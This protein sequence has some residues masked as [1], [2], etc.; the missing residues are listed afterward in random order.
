MTETVRL[1][2]PSAGIT[3]RHTAPTTV[4]P[5]ASDNGLAT[6]QGDTDPLTG[7]RVLTTW[8]IPSVPRTV[9]NH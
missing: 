5:V 1:Y 9:R 2:D 4:A 6:W 7:D 3:Y 8:A